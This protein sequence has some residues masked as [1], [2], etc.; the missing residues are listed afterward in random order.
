MTDWL[1]RFDD[2]VRGRRLGIRQFVVEVDAEDVRV[3]LGIGDLDLHGA[4]VAVLRFTGVA[5]LRFQQVWDNFPLGIQIVS[6]ADRGL[7]ELEYKVTDPENDIVSFL[8][9]DLL[10]EIEE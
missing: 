2:L 6:I 10:I 7:Q 8:C 3:S 5:E 4:S 9:A 1:G